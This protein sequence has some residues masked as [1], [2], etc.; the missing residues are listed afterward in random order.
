MD[1]TQ[2]DRLIQ[3]QTQVRD[4][5]LNPDVY[6]KAAQRREES[7]RTQSAAQAELAAQSRMTYERAFDREVRGEFPGIKDFQ[8]I[9]NGIDYAQ[10]RNLDGTSTVM[11]MKDIGRHRA[12]PDAVSAMDGS[13]DVAYHTLRGVPNDMSAISNDSNSEMEY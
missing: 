2:R 12:V 13:F 5:T 4:K 1:V 9:V 3:Y 11:K 10:M 7:A 6:R 8:P